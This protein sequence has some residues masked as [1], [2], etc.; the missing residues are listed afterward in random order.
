MRATSLSFLLLIATSLVAQWRPQIRGQDYYAPPGGS[1][2][3]CIVKTSGAVAWGSCGSGTTYA[4]GPSGGID[5]N[6]A[7]DPDEID[8]DPAVVADLATAQTF[9]AYKKFSHIRVASYAGVPTAADC[10]AADEEGK[11]AYREDTNTYYGCKAA[12]WTELSGSTSPTVAL[13]SNWVPG[14]TGTALAMPLVS[15]PSRLDLVYNRAAFTPATCRVRV[16]T[17]VDTATVTIGIFNTSGTRLC[18]GSD[19]LAGTAAQDAD[20]TMSCTGAIPEGFIYMG[21][22]ASSTSV[23]AQNRAAQGTV[24]M[25]AITPGTTAISATTTDAYTGNVTLTRNTTSNQVA[26]IGC[27]Q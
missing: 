24:M 11:L 15:T 6:T 23:Q 12:G 19:T 2:G 18:N 22:Y 4:G 5:I 17:S 10:N 1:D 26:I 20:A 8:Y 21:A 25:N 13:L 9:T 3:Q 7:T 16:T 14:D 27:T